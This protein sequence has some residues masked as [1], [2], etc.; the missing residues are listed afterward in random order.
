MNKARNKIHKMY[1]FTYMKS[2]DKQN[3]IS[4][5]KSD[6]C[7]LGIGVRKVCLEMVMREYFC[8]VAMSYIV[9]GIGYIGAY[10]C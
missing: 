8:L 4:C 5:Y 7:R 3:K 10:I 6:Q 9:S 2:S 1:Y